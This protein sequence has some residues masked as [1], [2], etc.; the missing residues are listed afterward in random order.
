MACAELT[1]NPDKEG[2]IH[3]FGWSPNSKEFGVIY[4]CTLS[5]I[6]ANVLIVTLS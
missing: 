3:D 4:G 2:P 6:I 1:Y 5:D